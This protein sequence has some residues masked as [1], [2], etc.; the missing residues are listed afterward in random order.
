MA[1][2]GQGPRFY[3]SKNAY[4]A[5]LDGERIR[6]CDGPQ[7]PDNDQL[8]Q[9]LYAE[10]IE[11]RR[12]YTA[13]DQAE[14]WS[15]LNAWLNYCLQRTEP[16]PISAGTLESYA[17]LLQS[18]ADTCGRRTWKDLTQDQISAWLATK[19]RSRKLAGTILKAACLWACGAGGLVKHCLLGGG[20]AAGALSSEERE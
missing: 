10:H 4:F 3:A 7:T 18:F 11:S 13:G 12:A 1:R 9:Q 20:G 6:L 16:P 19:G 15:I 2:T 5:N 8:A 17:R 14:V